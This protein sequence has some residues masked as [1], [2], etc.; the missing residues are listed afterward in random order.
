MSQ[1]WEPHD[2]Q[3]EAVQF[4]LEHGS[5]GLLLDPGLGKTSVTLKSIQLLKEAGEDHRTLV[6]APKRP[7]QRVWAQ[8]LEKWSD[9]KDLSMVRLHSDYGDKEEL[10]RT[11]ADVYVTNPET[12]PW[13]LDDNR[14]KLLEAPNLMID[15]LSKFKYTGTQRFKLLKPILGKFRRRGG[16]TGSP[17]P[18]G[19]LDL[20]GQAYIL[21]LGAALGKY[22]T[23]YRITY[24]YPT[25]F[26]GYEWKLQEG[27]EK[28]IQE[29]IRGLMLRM[30]AE[31]YIK[32]PKLVDHDIW[33]DL[34]APARKVYDAMESDLFAALSKGRTATAV[35]AAAASNKCRQIANGNVYL[36]GPGNFVGKRA[37]APIHT[38]KIDALLELVEELQGTPLLIAYQYDHDI[39]MLRAAFEAEFK[40]E[41]KAAEG[42]PHFDG[43]NAKRE[44]WLEDEWNAGRLPWVFGQSAAISHGLN[45]QGAAYHLAQYGVTWNY[46]DYDQLIR[47]LRRQ[48]NKN[49]VIFNHRI[50]ARDTVDMAMLGSLKGKATT[51]KGLLDALNDYRKA[52]K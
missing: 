31:D 47:R 12:L 52:R 41:I 23:H 24:F 19:Y 42:F 37:V 45:L 10:L 14:W 43:K 2:Y 8:E 16:L 38:A 27:A 11:P 21:D 15:E 32:M 30:D 34:P 50:L 26:G 18:N 25:G 9:F 51:Q 29:R 28:K 33:V 13:L 49:K 46:E 6:I 5:A 39:R 4:L 48:G 35:S 20:F 36:D 44:G 17:N 3:K 22:I 40:R 7:M 1:P